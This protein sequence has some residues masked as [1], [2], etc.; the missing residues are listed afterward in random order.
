MSPRPNPFKG[1]R[2]Q[3]LRLV[4]VMVASLLFQQLAVAAYV[5]VLPAGGSVEVATAAAEVTDCEAMQMSGADPT[6]V[7]C[8][9]HCQPEQATVTDHIKLAVPALALPAELFGSLLKPVTGAAWLGSAIS[10][11]H[12]DPPPR[13][14]YCSLQI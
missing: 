10:P 3:R 6:P 14:R 7:L 2:R 11:S 13:L 1:T 5:C 4:L 9:A 12:A 8:A